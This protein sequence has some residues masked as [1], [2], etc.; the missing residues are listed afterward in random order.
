MEAKTG[1]AFL[2][3]AEVAD[4]AR[5]SASIGEMET[6]H[7]LERC[8]HRMER[9]V[10]A[11]GGTAGGDDAAG[12]VATFPSPAA[13][14]EAAIEMQGRVE[15]LPR[16]SGITLMVRIGMHAGAAGDTKVSDVAAQLASFAS[17][18]QVLLS[19]ALAGELPAAQKGKVRPVEMP[20]SGVAGSVFEIVRAPSALQ[21]PAQDPSPSPPQVTAFLR[22]RV[23]GSEIVLGPDRPVA[24]L[25]RGSDAD[26]VVRD[27]RASRSHGQIEFRGGRYVLIDRSANGTWVSFEGGTQMVLKDDEAILRGRGRIGF[28]HATDGGTDDS[29]EF[30]LVG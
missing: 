18:G 19:A 28:G 13:A 27:P 11:F 14:V 25:G 4:P 17:P 12:L 24:S 30:E 16:L 9:A 15:A 8:R 7:A 20:A 29:V 26:I 1:M 3:V 23:A 22:L 10:A 5:L 21:V 6:R 2:L